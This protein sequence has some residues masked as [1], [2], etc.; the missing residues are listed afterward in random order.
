MSTLMH[1][2]HLLLLEK[3]HRRNETT[4]FVTNLHSRKE[5]RGRKLSRCSSS[6]VALLSYI[7]HLGVV[8]SILCNQ[9]ATAK[10]CKRPPEEEEQERLEFVGCNDKEVTKM[11]RTKRDG[12]EGLRAPLDRNHELLETVCSYVHLCRVFP[13]KLYREMT[14][15]FPPKEALAP[16]KLT[17]HKLRYKIDRVGSLLDLPRR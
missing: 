8:F 5:R 7:G 15:Y 2:R 13:R 1:Q 6:S 4:W 12:C 3:K 10:R 11:T 9:D 16:A 14:E 17:S